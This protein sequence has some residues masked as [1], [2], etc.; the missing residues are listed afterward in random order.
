MEAPGVAND[1]L[2]IFMCDMPFNFVVK[3]ALDWLN[4][5]GVL[6]EVAWLRTLSTH[7]PI[8]AGLA[9]AVQE[10]SGTMHKFHKAFND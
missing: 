7:I 1:D 8:Y 9:Q 2:E 5:P 4:D 6:A 3:Q 10:L